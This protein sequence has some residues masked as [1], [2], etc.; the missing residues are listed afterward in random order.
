MTKL[1][2]Q[3]TIVHTDSDTF[4]L[5]NA[6]R[7]RTIPNNIKTKPSQNPVNKSI[8][9]ILKFWFIKI[10]NKNIPVLYRIKSD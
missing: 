7:I 9:G 1:F 3:V 6:N 4:H 8:S 5:K 10:I 2:T